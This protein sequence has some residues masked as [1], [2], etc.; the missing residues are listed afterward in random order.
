MNREATTNTPATRK[1]VDELT[2]ELRLKDVSG[3]S[4][5]DALATV[6]EFLAD[7]GQAPQEAFGTP[8]EYA[9][10]LAEEM[11]PAGGKANGTGLGASVTL[12]TTSLAAFLI[13]S[14]ALSPWLKGTDLLVAGWQLA[15]LAVLVGLVLALPFYLNFMVRHWWALVAVPVIGGAAGVLSAIL[16]P[17]TPTDALLVLPPAP[18]LLATVGVMVA[19]SIVGT[20]IA[21]R[22]APDPVTGPLDPAP[23]K[24]LAARW[25]EILTQWLFPIFA[26]VLL[27]FT[28]LL[29]ALS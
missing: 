14:A 4:I 26:L 17:D 25:F 16:A 13:F 11:M 10:R 21:L 5:G 6:Q 3:R 9:A 20:A 19:L 27:G 18:V 28:A 22:E 29:E 15:S 23:A 7:S 24:T 1:W 8:R 2:L 12:S